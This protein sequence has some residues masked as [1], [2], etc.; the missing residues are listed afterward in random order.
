[1]TGRADLTLGLLC[2]SLMA[3]L[4]AMLLQSDPI[5]ESLKQRMLSQPTVNRRRVDVGVQVAH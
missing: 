3:M 2:A 5:Y 4:V 1:M